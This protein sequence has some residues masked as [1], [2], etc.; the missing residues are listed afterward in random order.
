V[1]YKVFLAN[2]KE[3]TDTEVRRFVVDKEVSSSFTY[4]REKVASVF[5]SLRPAAEF[6][7]SWTDCDGDLVTIATDEELIIA[8]T[9]MT[10]PLYR[11]HV[12]PK[13]GQKKKQDGDNG[14][15]SGPLHPGVTCDGCE[16]PIRGFRYKC[17]V[18]EDYDLCA[19]CEAAGK[20][21]GHNMMRIAG[22]DVV[23]PKNLFKRLHKMHERAE[24]RSR[25]KSQATGNTGRQDQEFPRPPGHH[26]PPPPPHG[27]G[28]HAPPPP[29]PHGCQWGPF[30]RGRGM[31]RGRGRGFGMGNGWGFGGMG[32]PGGNFNFSQSGF[33][34]PAFE[35]MMKGW[36][37]EGYESQQ[38]QEQGNQQGHGEHEK[39]HGEA[40]GA[41]KEAHEQAHAQAESMA[42]AAHEAAAAAAH[43]AAAAAA[44]GAAAAATAG[45]SADYLQNVGSF[46]AAALDPLG[47][48]V[49]VHVE[50]PSA[51]QGEDENEKSMNSSSDD[52]DEWTV[53]SDKKNPKEDVIEIP[54]QKTTEPEKEKEKLYPSLPKE[55]PAEE[56]LAKN[57]TTEA[58]MDVDNQEASGS[59]TA[60]TTSAKTGE[61]EPVIAVHPDPKIQVA[62]QA[63][64]NMGFS[65]EGGWLSN[66]L[67]A[68]N[69]DIGK[70]LDILQPVKK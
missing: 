22:P 52:D 57:P 25:S 28:H 43:E 42:A 53:V 65:N 50:T 3:K 64:M 60:D 68:K 67:E 8:L 1:S 5:P 51:S 35:A 26:G 46:V 32:Q 38:G 21:P 15:E 58:S 63:M 24:A 20:H 18:C 2:G 66:L 33:A 23:W 19:K 11:L 41:A 47:I 17:M 14:E 29:P 16:K 55:T 48:D 54:I 56:E 61:P 70:V 59:A 30:A 34:G 62:L 10:G 40:C 45:S 31:F 6:S 12:T 69:G 27:P 36:M 4:L 39:A 37:G 44:M 7:I 49:Q 13:P 9:E